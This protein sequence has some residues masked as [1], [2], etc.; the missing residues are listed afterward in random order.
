MVEE[1][2]ERMKILLKL[3]PDYCQE[4]LVKHF[5]DDLYK[6][7]GAIIKSSEV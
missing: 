3:C 1:M 5:F 4:F 2:I 7:E 6:K